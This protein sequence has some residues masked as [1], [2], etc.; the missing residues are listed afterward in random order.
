M[1]AAQRFV[2]FQMKSMT[3]EDV[4]KRSLDV[5]FELTLFFSILGEVELGLNL[6][7]SGFGVSTK[8]CQKRLS[9]DPWSLARPF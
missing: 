7:S 4:S 5:G 1:S 3:V 2:F 6:E 9:S 8:F